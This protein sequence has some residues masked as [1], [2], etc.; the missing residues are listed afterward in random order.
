MD[1]STGRDC[2]VEDFFPAVID[3]VPWLRAGRSGIALTISRMRTP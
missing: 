2:S 1:L 3:F